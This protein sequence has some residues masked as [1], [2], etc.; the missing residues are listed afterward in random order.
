MTEYLMQ[1]SANTISLSWEYK[2]DMNSDEM[3]TDYAS[4]HAI[5]LKQDLW[6]FKKRDGEYV[7]VAVYYFFVTQLRLRRARYVL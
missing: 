6:L 7:F 2:F 3:A 1:F 5:L 4:R